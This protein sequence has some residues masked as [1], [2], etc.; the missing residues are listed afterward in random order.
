MAIELFN[1]TALHPFHY[2][3][4]SREQKENVTITFFDLQLTYGP[5]PS[6]LQS[7]HFQ[8]G[9]RNCMTLDFFIPFDKVCC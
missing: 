3:S 1:I 8:Y 7:L 2:E 6:I 4:S 5:L 9:C